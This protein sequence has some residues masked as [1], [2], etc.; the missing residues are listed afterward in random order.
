MSTQHDLSVA[1]DV[2][3]A[4]KLLSD[5]DSGFSRVDIVTTLRALVARQRESEATIAHL[6]KRLDRQ[7]S[8]VARQ[9]RVDAFAIALVSSGWD[10]QVYACANA[11]EEARG[12]Y[13]AGRADVVSKRDA[14]Q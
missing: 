2:A 14:N 12:R 9:S 1:I 4:E 13:L 8:E 6:L 7:E 5:I 3:F 11:L 10:D